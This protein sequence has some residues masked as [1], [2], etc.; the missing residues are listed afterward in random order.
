MH[1]N[2]V[3]VIVK[4]IVVSIAITASATTAV[5]VANGLHI[6]INHSK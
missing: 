6:I 3:I 2:S 1:I 4:A 5:A